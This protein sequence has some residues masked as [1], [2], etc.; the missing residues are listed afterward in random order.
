MA[1]KKSP[2]LQLAREK[3][4]EWISQLLLLY[5]D[6]NVYLVG[7]AVRDMLLKR[8]TKDYDFVIQGLPRKKLEEF[9]RTRGAVNFVGSRFGVFKFIPNSLKDSINESFD[10]ALPRTEHSMYH[11]GHYRDF[12][13][14]TNYRLSIEEDLSRRDFTINA[15]CFDFRKNIIIDPW[16]GLEDISQKRI[17]TVGS[18]I[19][20]FREDYSRMLRALRFQCQLGFSLE[21]QTSQAIKKCMKSINAEIIPFEKKKKSHKKIRVVPY[22]VIA[23]EIARACSASPVQAFDLF[24]EYSVFSFLIPELNTMKKCIQDPRWH[25][26]GDVWTHTRLTLSHLYGPEF[27]K[28]FGRDE[29]DPTLIFAALFHDLGKPYTI[30]TPEKDGVD[31]IHFYGHDRVGAEITRTILERLRFSSVPHVAIHSDQIVWLIKNHLVLLNGDV[32]AMKAVTLEKY[33]LKDSYVGGLLLRLIFVDSYASVRKDKKT[34]LS[35]YYECLKRLKKLKRRVNNKTD[36]PKALVNGDD[37]MKYCR[38]SP[39]KKIGE[40][41]LAVREEQLTKRIRTKKEAFA[42]LKKK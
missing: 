12:S 19:D 39:G 13:V 20:R 24:D 1:L 2:F 22:E 21:E 31:R 5:T 27:R 37:I 35:K 10:I 17:R 36:L 14:R 18:P 28:Q 11:T 33:F 30:Q 6:A 25:S 42:F 34:S 9:L 23:Q 8:K 3:K 16:N 32:S 15:L 38:L 7:G 40:L 26:E 4:F 41:L 29:L